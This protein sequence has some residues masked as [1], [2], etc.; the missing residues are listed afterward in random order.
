[1]KREEKSKISWFVSN[2]YF[3]DPKEV[4][5]LVV[6]LLEDEEGSIGLTTVTP[7]LSELIEFNDIPSKFSNSFVSLLFFPSY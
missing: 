4:L 5:E 7:I 6:V 3:F 2:Q 1:M